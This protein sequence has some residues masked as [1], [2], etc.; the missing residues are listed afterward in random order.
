MISS[1]STAARSQFTLI[2]SWPQPLSLLLPPSIISAIKLTFREWFTAAKATTGLLQSQRKNICWLY[3]WVPPPRIL[4]LQLS[5]PAQPPALEM[6]LN[7]FTCICVNYDTSH[8][9]MS[10]FEK[11][12]YQHLLHTHIDSHPPLLFTQNPMHPETQIIS[13]LLCT[14]FFDKLAS[15][16]A[17]RP[18]MVPASLYQHPPAVP[19]QIG[20][21][22]DQQH[23]DLAMYHLQDQGRK[24]NGLHLRVPPSHPVSLLPKSRKPGANV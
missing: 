7:P 15:I 10:S 13:N 19:F 20:T 8:A 16:M 1:V 22:C 12:L 17:L 23:A 2:A 24:D 18:P 9:C 21:R 5:H 11:C 4:Q 6:T 3:H 14:S